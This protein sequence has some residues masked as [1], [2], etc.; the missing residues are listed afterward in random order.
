MANEKELIEK[1]IVG[2]QQQ[3][4]VTREAVERLIE[5]TNGN[6]RVRFVSLKGYNSDK[7][8]N[9]EVANQIVNI[10][11]SYAKMLDKDA[12]TLNNVVLN[13][14]VLP[15]V[16]TWDYE[17]YDL[18]G[19]SVADFKKQVKE[20]L[21][22]ALQE[23]RNPKTGSRESNDIW[24][25]KALAFN[26]NTLRLSVFGASISKEVVQEGVY[27]KVKSA[28]KTVAKQIIQKAV[29]PRTAKL[30][31]FTM[32]NLNGMKMDG[33]TLEIGGGQKDGIE[34]Q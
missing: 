16:E 21:E 20:A 10:N 5:L 17:R 9:T 6:E 26:T 19:V 28:P 7:S 29:E 23:L 32:D 34:I 4:G 15:L 11:A 25:N 27:K 13:R 12:L 18:N 24:L 33:E 22:M 1:A 14:D 8:L 3:Y 2:I 30:R 31:R